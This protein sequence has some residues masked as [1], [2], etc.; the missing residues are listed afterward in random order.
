[1]I[2]QKKMNQM[3][4]FQLNTTT[5]QKGTLGSW[6]F[7]FSTTGIHARALGASK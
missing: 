4:A 2:I 3:R 5:D 6:V 7:G 1:M